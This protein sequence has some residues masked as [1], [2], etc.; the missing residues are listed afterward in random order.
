MGKRL[1]DAYDSDWGEDGDSGTSIQPGNFPNSVAPNQPNPDKPEYQVI[2]VGEDGSIGIE[3]FC[4]GTTPFIADIGGREIYLGEEGMMHAQIMEIVSDGALMGPLVR[5][6]LDASGTHLTGV[7]REEDNAISDALSDFTGRGTFMSRVKRDPAVCPVCDELVSECDCLSWGEGADWA[8]DPIDQSSIREMKPG[9]QAKVAGMENFIGNVPTGFMSQLREYD[10]PDVEDL[11][12]DIAENGINEPLW[13]DFNDLTGE[14]HLSE[15][16]HRIAIAEKLGLPTVPVGVYRSQR[17]SQSPNGLRFEYVGPERDHLGNP[18][19]PQ[20]M[21]PSDIGL[22]VVGERTASR[23]TALRM[24]HVSPSFNRDLIASE[25]LN[26]HERGLEEAGIDSPWTYNNWDQ[27]PGNYFFPNMR[28]AYAY[29]ST[30]SESGRSEI[31]NQTGYEFDIYEVDVDGLPMFTDPEDQLI[32]EVE[33]TGGGSSNLDEVGLPDE[34]GIFGTPARAVTPD[35]VS[36]RRIRLVDTVS[37]EILGDHA[38]DAHRHNFDGMPTG[39]ERLPMTEVPW[40]GH[41]LNPQE[42]AAAWDK[43]LAKLSPRESS[44]VLEKA[45]KETGPQRARRWE[46]ISQRLAD[47]GFPSVGSTVHEFDDGWTVKHHADAPEQRAVGEIMNNCWRGTRGEDEDRAPGQLFDRP[48]FN[49]RFALHDDKGMPQVAFNWEPNWTENWSA[50]TFTNSR[51]PKRGL[52]GMTDRSHVLAQ[53]LAARNNR[54]D[55]EHLNRLADWAASQSEDPRL[56]VGGGFIPA[57]RE[58]LLKHYGPQGGSDPAYVHY[59]DDPVP[60]QLGEPINL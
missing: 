1:S 35:G 21:H 26:G 33:V 52:D 20:Y 40:P 19:P 28:D 14:V 31:I 11:Q 51:S 7:D 58:N 39:W 36:P 50:E 8:N 9:I 10:R 13:V 53:P 34:T 56:Q 24:F 30:L 60:A 57:S 41:D 54:P 16:N 22:P 44:Y 2:R 43:P 37:K 49:N 15:G 47:E 45:S 59:P 3:G 4:P 18:R 6:Y 25:G 46:D 27:P 17:K 55:A 12:E 42:R 5:G 23:K 48:A 38:W 29:A 32:S